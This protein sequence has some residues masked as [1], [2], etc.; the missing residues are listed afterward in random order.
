MP[1]TGDPNQV[2]N[3]IRTFEL[4][5]A[6]EILDRFNNYVRPPCFGHPIT[7][8]PKKQNTYFQCFSQITSGDVGDE[9][10]EQR[11]EKDVVKLLLALVG[12]I[13]TH[14]NIAGHTHIG[15]EAEVSAFYT[16]IERW[17][18]GLAELLLGPGSLTSL[19]E[20]GKEVD[21]QGGPEESLKVDV[22]ISFAHGI[23]R[24][25]TKIG[26]E[27]KAFGIVGPRDSPR[28]TQQ[29]SDMKSY[30]GQIAT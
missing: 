16:S 9:A 6:S 20:V 11:I 8:V 12:M 30:H 4:K 24:S 28:F 17:V 10:W 25:P 2:V 1:L 23:L 29:T 14:I 21:L 26:V 5:R 13:E 18:I 3:H 7:R 27:I 15:N 22:G 19:R